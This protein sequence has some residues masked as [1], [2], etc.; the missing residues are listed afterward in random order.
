MKKF[1]WFSISPLALGTWGMGGGYWSADYSNDEN[2]IKAIVKAIELGITAI[3]T[4]EMYGNGHA[5]EL[6]GKAIKNFK[7]EELFIITKVWPNHAKY[8]DV[9]KSA[10]ASSKRLGTYIDLYFLH[11]PSNVPIC[12]TIKAFEDL[13]DK[14]VIRYFGL[15]NFK[16]KEIEKASECVKKYEIVAVENHYSLWDRGDEETLEYANKKGLLYLAYTPI[17][18]GRIKNDKFLS[19]IA[20]KYNKTPIQVAL[21]WYIK[22]PSLVPIVK[23]SNIS[24]IEENVGAL[25]WELSDEDWKKINEHFK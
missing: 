17:E 6:V 22:I 12:E 14:G 10:I 9:I 8:E 19:E 15:S 23:S 1:K 11:W 25:G 18:K 5:E 20:K 7:R 13:V 16:W 4:A 2:D 24:H 3:D 21:N